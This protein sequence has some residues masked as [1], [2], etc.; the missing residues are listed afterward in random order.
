VAVE[1]LLHGVGHF[2]DRRPGAGRIDA[3]RQ[4]VALARRAIWSARSS[5]ASVSAWSRSARSRAQLVKLLLAHRGVVHL[6]DV[7]R[8]LALR[9]VTVDAHNGLLAAE[10]MRAWVLAAASSIRIF[11][12][13]CSM[14]LAIPP[15]SSISAMC[16]IARREVLRQPLDK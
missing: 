14:A 11:G 12:M 9:L 1:H 3:Q 13:P 16:S 15:S 7:D 8:L 6:Q 2:A 10:S 5:A 4:Q